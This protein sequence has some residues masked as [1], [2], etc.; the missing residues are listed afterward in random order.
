MLKGE[1][2]SADSI[3]VYKGMDIG[4]AK[5]SAEDQARIPHHLIDIR[6]L[7]DTFNIVDFYYEARQ[8]CES[9][10]ARGKVP[11]VVG[12]S[13]FYFRALLYGPPG[14]PPPMPDLRMVLEEEMEHLGSEALY[15]R[16]KEYDPVYAATITPHDR[17]KI[18]RALEIVTLTGEKVSKLQWKEIAP[19]PILITIAGLFIAPGKFSTPRSMRGVNRCWREV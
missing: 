14:G 5:V 19:F 13:G 15:E 9:I 17:Q 12:G 10:L 4:T 1:I 11:I 2:V 18:V 16:L 7:H 6:Q 3:Q 8:S